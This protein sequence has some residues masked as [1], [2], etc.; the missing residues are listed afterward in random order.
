M[1]YIVFEL[2]IFFFTFHEGETIY[3][4]SLIQYNQI[5][6]Y[7]TGYERLNRFAIFDNK[8]EIAN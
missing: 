4:L 8:S 3:V 6:K 7:I 5:H 1:A 2:H